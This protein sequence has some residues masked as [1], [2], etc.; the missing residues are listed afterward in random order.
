ME[1][2]RFDAPVGS[3][4]S[5]P[6]PMTNLPSDPGSFLFLEAGPEPH[7]T[8]V[9]SPI[10]RSRYSCSS[11]TWA[12]ALCRVAMTGLVDG[13]LNGLRSPELSYSELSG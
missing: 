5:A 2:S 6:S 1:S 13:R 10:D 3:T 9:A 7:R 12:H 4:E 11:A 8:A